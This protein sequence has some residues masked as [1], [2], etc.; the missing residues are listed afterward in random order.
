MPTVSMENPLQSIYFKKKGVERLLKRNEGSTISAEFIDETRKEIERN[1]KNPTAIHTENDENDI[2]KTMRMPTVNEN[3]TE[4]VEHRQ[5]D[6][7]EEEGR[8]YEFPSLSCTSSSPSSLSMDWS[9]PGM[10]EGTDPKFGYDVD[11]ERER[12]RL[13]KIKK[14]HND[15]RKV[16]N[17]ISMEQCDQQSPKHRR[18]ESIDTFEL[19]LK[20]ATCHQEDHVTFK[21]WIRC[22]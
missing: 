17:N 14:E 6:D 12:N 16:Y 22:F 19:V 15:I 8:A 10:E 3:E 21:D 1:E 2:E 4:S 11:D 9:L 13:R 18:T 7:D 5:D 20:L